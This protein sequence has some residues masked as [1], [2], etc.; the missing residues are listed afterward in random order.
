MQVKE[1][2]HRLCHKLFP[3]DAQMKLTG[4][5]VLT[6]RPKD[7]LHQWFL[8]LYGEHIIPAMVY[9]YTQVLQQLDLIC[10]DRN[11]DLGGGLRGCSSNHVQRSGGQSLSAP[12][13]QT[14][15]CS[16]KHLND[17]DFARICCA[18]S[19]GVCQ[20]NRQCKIHWRQSLLSNADAAFRCA[21]PHHS[22][23]CRASHRQQER[24]SLHSVLSLPLWAAAAV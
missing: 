9:R 12:C 1:A 5:D 18:L 21:R 7:E 14:S 20:E 22:S 6:S 15:G 2:E 4:F 24:F 23:L 17:G 16:G 11:V 8:G 3:P 19:G 10:K 13:R